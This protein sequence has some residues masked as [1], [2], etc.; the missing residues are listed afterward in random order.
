MGG[1]AMACGYNPAPVETQVR[2]VRA[3]AWVTAWDRNLHCGPESCVQRSLP[4]VGAGDDS[5]V[6]LLELAT[7]S[8]PDL[9]KRLGAGKD[10]GGK[11][12]GCSSR[13]V[14]D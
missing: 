6:T 2:G 12:L 13:D 5:G 14:A 8:K 4:C 1:P 3:H 10:P 11:L 7:L 9:Q